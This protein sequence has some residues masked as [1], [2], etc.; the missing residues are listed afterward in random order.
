M[1]LSRESL[2]IVNI[3]SYFQ[4]IL[5]EDLSKKNIPKLEKNSKY[6]PKYDKLYKLNDSLCYDIIMR[7]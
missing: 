4:T 3:F 5:S 1:I 2:Y 6:L 7:L